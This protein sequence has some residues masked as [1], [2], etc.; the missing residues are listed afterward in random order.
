MRATEWF[1]RLQQNRESRGQSRHRD[2]PKCP[3]EFQSEPIREVKIPRARDDELSSARA[4]VK[5][6]PQMQISKLDRLNRSSSPTILD[7]VQNTNSL[8][9]NSPLCV[10]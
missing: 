5:S 7:L 9:A 3:A 6:F 1:A 2:S 8:P 4:Y 10:R